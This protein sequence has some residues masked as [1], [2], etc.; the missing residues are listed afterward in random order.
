[1]KQRLKNISLIVAS[2]AMLL[3]TLILGKYF[4]YRW[5]NTSIQS[6]RLQILPL[7]KSFIEPDELQ[8]FF[9]I[10]DST[11]AKVDVGQIEARLQK[12]DYISSAE[13]YKDLNGNLVVSVEQYHPIARVI[14]TKSYYIDEQGKDRP[15]SKHYTENVVLVFGGLNAQNREKTLELL[16][17]VYRDKTLKN[18]VSEVHINNSGF[19]L[20]VLDLKASIR[21]TSE[22]DLKTQLEKLKAIYAYLKSNHKTNAYT[23]IDLRFKNQAVCK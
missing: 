7:D 13:V 21:M 10:K 15:L 3:L 12:N 18:L 22:K 19:L 4:D 6:S 1:M 14:G 11:Q 17:A 9:S 16:Q 5:Q 23:N 8:A 2:F 20:R